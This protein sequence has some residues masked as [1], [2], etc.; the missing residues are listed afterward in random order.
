MVRCFICGLIIQTYKSDDVDDYGE[1]EE[2]GKEKREG[3]AI[4]KAMIS[5]ML[6]LVTQQLS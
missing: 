2:E 1:E 6:K 3:H 5:T 4:T